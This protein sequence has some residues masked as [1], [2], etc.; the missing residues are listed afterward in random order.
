LTQIQLLTH[1]FKIAAKLELI[2]GTFEGLSNSPHA[3]GALG[4]SAASGLALASLDPSKATWRRLGFLSFDTNERSGFAARELKSV[5]LNNVHAHLLRLVIH[6][7]HANAANA[8]SQVRTR[9]CPRLGCSLH[10]PGGVKPD[11]QSISK[12]RSAL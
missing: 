5:A 6:K 12:C 8:F 10:F 1:E 9:A 11:G 7:C 2:V 4:A 3:D